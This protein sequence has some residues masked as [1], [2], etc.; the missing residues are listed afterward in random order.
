MDLAFTA[1]ESAFRDEVRAFLGERLPRRLS[2]KV[3]SGKRLQRADMLEWH[4]ILNERGWLASHWPRE[5]G[6]P[7]WDAV[8]KFIFENECALAGAPRVVA[9]G[10]SMLGPVLIR[11]GSDEQKR[12]WLPRILDGSDWWCQGLSLIHI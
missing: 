3:R 8:Q 7:G 1:E 9:F 10:V 11:Y 12:Y 5:H 6:G 2:D 4:A